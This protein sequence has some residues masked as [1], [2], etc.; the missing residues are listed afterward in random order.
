MCEYEDR[1]K[2]DLPGKRINRSDKEN[3][4]RFKERGR[5]S[6][7]NL[8]ISKCDNSECTSV[9]IDL[10]RGCVCSI[11]VCE[12]C[13]N[14]PVNKLKPVADKCSSL[15]IVCKRCYKNEEVLKV[16]IPIPMSKKYR[17]SNRSKHF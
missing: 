15:Y 3:M 7:K 2:K 13:K 6:A 1:L 12:K 16:A 5:G 9:N 10:I 17:R 14:N 11:Y 4:F 8:T